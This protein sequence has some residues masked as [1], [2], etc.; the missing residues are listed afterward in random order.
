MGVRISITKR[1]LG[2]LTVSAGVIAK[3]WN[4]EACDFVAKIFS[5]FSTGVTSFLSDHK[6][7][8]SQQTNFKDAIQKA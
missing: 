6:I 8:I 2:H 1:R 3:C 7:L 4:S 5:P